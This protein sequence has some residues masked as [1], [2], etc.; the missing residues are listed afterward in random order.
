MFSTIIEYSFDK[1]EFH[2]HSTKDNFGSKNDLWTDMPRV[3]TEKKILYKHSSA[4]ISLTLERFL[5]FH[6]LEPD[7][8]LCILI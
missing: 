7:A 3:L 8:A 5:S 1:G 2:S 4:F 6:I